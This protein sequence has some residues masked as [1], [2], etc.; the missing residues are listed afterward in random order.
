VKV[1]ALLIVLAGLVIAIVPQSTNCESGADDAATA[2]AGDRTALAAVADTTAPATLFASMTTVASSSIVP[3]MKCLWSARGGLVVGI[4]LA[5]VGGL[6]F[7]ARR[8]ETRRALAIVAA[9][10]GVFAILVPTSLIGTCGSEAMICNT[11]MKPIMMVAGGIALAASVALLVVNELR[12][13]G[14]TEASAAS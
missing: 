13:E 3:K 12:R 5:V 11:T 9:C 1:L 6:L 14:P 4:T 8:R 7:F 10:L 2:S